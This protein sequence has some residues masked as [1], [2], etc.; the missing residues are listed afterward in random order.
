M[1]VFPLLGKSTHHQNVEEGKLE[2]EAESDDD[3]YENRE[4]N[5]FSFLQ[6]GLVF[7]LIQFLLLSAAAVIKCDTF[8]Y[9]LFFVNFA[10]L[11][12]IL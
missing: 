3:E 12:F 2:R 8:N 11:L 6:R 1:Y 7:Q 9:F 10:L 5:D 4:R